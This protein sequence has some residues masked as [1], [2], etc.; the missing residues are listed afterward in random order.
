MAGQRD[1]HKVRVKDRGDS[2]AAMHAFSHKFSLSV[3][4][5]LPKLLRLR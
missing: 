5:D 2:A 1:W 3:L 4:K